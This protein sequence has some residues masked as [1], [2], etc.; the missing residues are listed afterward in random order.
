[1]I[2]IAC[3]ITNFSLHLYKLGCMDR[4]ASWCSK[5]QMRLNISKCDLLCISNKRLPSYYINNHNLQWVS[6]VKY[7]G[8]FVDDKLSWNHHI[9]HAKVLNLLQHH[10]YN[11]KA[12]SKF[13]AFRALVL[14]VLDYTSIFWN[15]H[16]QKSVSA[17]DKI[18]NRAACWVCGSR[19]NQISFKWSKSSE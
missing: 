17:L 1:M 13:K 4:F 6:S 8:V 10:M 11:C 19:F 14:P 7:L 5:W 12:S 15:P 16:T 2:P 18:Q 3:K 9:S